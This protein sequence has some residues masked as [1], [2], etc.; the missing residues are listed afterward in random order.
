MID[1]R[2][3]GD[4][5]IPVS[6]SKVPDS[7]VVSAVTG[8]AACTGIFT[9]GAPHIVIIFVGYKIIVGL[10]ESFDIANNLLLTLCKLVVFKRFVLPNNIWVTYF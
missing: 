6:I 3:T 4:V 10:F 2:L 1:F 9:S 8:A 7:T 5:T